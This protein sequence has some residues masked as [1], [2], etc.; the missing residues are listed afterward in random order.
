MEIKRL[1]LGPLATNTYYLEKEGHV[2][3][4]DPASKAEKLFPLLEDKILDAVLL[5]HGH[6]DHIKAVDGLYKKYKMPI[7]LHQDDFIQATS[8]ELYNQA[9]ASFGFSSI[10]NSPILAMDEGNQKIGPFEFEVYHTP[11]HT[12]GSVLYR[13]GQDLFTGDTLF[14]NGVGRTD[15]YGGST[16][17]LR[18]SLR[19]IRGLDPTLIIHPGHDEESLLSLELKHNPYL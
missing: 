11:G 7:Y 13:F 15:L 3:L 14:K 17:S 10:I 1:V 4:I 9:V 5:T 18:Q 19:F 16:S 12:E 8:K 2:L 6:F